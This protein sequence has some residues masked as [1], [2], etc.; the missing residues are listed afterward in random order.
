MTS[1]RFNWML[2]LI[3]CPMLS[4]SQ[5]N[6][7]VITMQEETTDDPGNQY[8]SGKSAAVDLADF[9]PENEMKSLL[10]SPSAVRVAGIQG[11]N[12]VVFDALTG[13]LLGSMEI[14]G[15][16]IQLLWSD[17]TFF[18]VISLS[19]NDDAILVSICS[20]TSLKVTNS[21]SLS[22]ADHWLSG[23]NYSGSPQLFFEGGARLRPNL[24]SLQV[25]TGE[26]K[27]EIENPGDV[28][29]W[30]SGISGAGIY[31]LHDKGS[32]WQ[33]GR[34][35]GNTHSSLVDL[36]AGKYFEFVGAGKGKVIFYSD[37]GKKGVSVSEVNDEPTD[38]PT[39]MS[40]I[41][42]TSHYTSPVGYF[43]SGV[44]GY[45]LKSVQPDYVFSNENNTSA[46][47][48]AK[49]YFSPKYVHCIDMDPNAMRYIFHVTS[50]TEPG[51]YYLF[52]GASGKF[53]KLADAGKV[54]VEDTNLNAYAITEIEINEAYKVQA[55]SLIPSDIQDLKAP[56]IVLLN[57]DAKHRFSFE[58]NAKAQMIASRGFKVL[59]LN[60][61]GGFDFLTNA[62]WIKT[63]S[64]PGEPTKAQVIAQVVKTAIGQGQLIGIFATAEAA[65]L[66]NDIDVLSMLPGCDAYAALGNFVHLNQG[67]PLYFDVH[68]P[69]GEYFN[70]ASET[71]L[72]SVPVKI[73]DV[74]TF[75]GLVNITPD[76]EINL[77]SGDISYP[78]QK[79]VYRYYSRNVGEAECINDVLKYMQKSLKY[80][81]KI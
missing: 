79:H 59:L 41:Q 46:W 43:G 12:A 6:L 74:S 53:S 15:K 44:D 10:I 58:Y 13:D 4:Y 35:S 26:V 23:G 81:V 50:A 1:R 2:L 16:P 31:S 64:D 72:F 18:S 66:A 73:R 3:L 71:R 29:R 80:F 27:L 33:I 20:A 63:N 78:D 19:D 40:G 34:R 69:N 17:D 42:S 54:K 45:R 67:T 77:R 22:S 68:I 21:V 48:S 52:N 65:L 36:E 11:K 24:Y 8:Y 61:E 51:T 37:L 5:G 60:T 38:A 30:C 70:V 14:V 76:I 75:L 49:R 47:L 56:L 28:L 39:V 32:V 7:N 55:L 25:A 62:E 9:V 57:E